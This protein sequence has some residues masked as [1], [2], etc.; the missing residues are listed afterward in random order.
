MQPRAVFP[1]CQQTSAKCDNGVICIHLWSTSTLQ[2]H[3]Y[4]F[5]PLLQEPVLY[6]GYIFAVVMLMAPILGSLA[7]VMANRLSIGTQVMLRA[8]LTAAI[9]RKA[10]RLSSRWGKRGEGGGGVDCGCDRVVE[11]TGSHV[12]GG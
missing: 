11:Q 7:A 6:K 8:E 4:C 3:H 9:Y 5:G 1:S 2:K 10:L 12:I